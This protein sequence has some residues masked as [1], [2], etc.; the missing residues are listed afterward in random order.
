MK[1]VSDQHSVVD[2]TLSGG[3]RLLIGRRW[4]VIGVL[5]LSTVIIGIWS[6]AIGAADIGVIE[7]ARVIWHKITGL[8][9][10]FT[11][12]VTG[13]VWNLRLPRILLA[14]VAGW[15]LASS[16][17]V[18]QA[19]LRNPLASPFT[20][21]VA[22]GA[23]FGAAAAMVLAASLWGDMYMP[24]RTYIV[25][26]GAFV[27]GI[28]AIIIIEAL[29]SL[30]GAG[31][32]MLILAGVAL[33]YMFNAGVSLMKYFVTHDQLNMI[34]VWMMG[35]LYQAEWSHVLIL[36]PVVAI[37][38][39]FLESLAWDLNALGAGDEVASSMGVSVQKLR[40]RGARFSAFLVSIIIAFTGVIGFIGL[41]APHICRMLLGNDNRYLIPASS[42]LGA[43][44]LLVADAA[45][46]TVAA[47]AEIP[48][49]IITSAIGAPFFLIMLIRKRRSVW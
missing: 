1:A 47:P 22:A 48:V 14:L 31:P 24:Y 11:P 33:G 49:G 8:G 32:E 9:A 39:A 44:I 26:A 41:V 34:T 5:L 10:D 23:A 40:K 16:G 19:V 36:F 27:F 38:V 15:G 7:A 13:V 20:L 17:V 42:L 45:A 28:L 43:L 3:F 46:K 18:M 25:A 4:M 6:I 37:G 30:R 2:E 12:Y 29:A 21:G 35:G